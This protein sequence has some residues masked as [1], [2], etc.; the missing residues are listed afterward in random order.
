MTDDFVNLKN[1]GFLRLSGNPTLQNLPDF[2]QLEKLR[3]L[4]FSGESSYSNV[5]SAKP[6]LL[7]QILSTNMPLLETLYA[8]RWK[9]GENDEI[10]EPHKNMPNLKT[11]KK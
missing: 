8:E 5:P 3:E 11:F 9:I 10:S 1:L 6:E 2:S 7:K 4:Y